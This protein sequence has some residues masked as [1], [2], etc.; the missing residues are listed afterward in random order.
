MSLPVALHVS[1]DCG[2][3]WR[4]IPVTED[5]MGEVLAQQRQTARPQTQVRITSGCLTPAQRWRSGRPRTVCAASAAG[6]S[7]RSRSRA[8]GG[9]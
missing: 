2:A 7:R 4:R 3:T 9:C 5:T 8:L 6:R 1:L